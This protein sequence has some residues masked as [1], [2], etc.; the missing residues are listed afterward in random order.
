VL[1][2]LPFL[3]F[4]CLKLWFSNLYITMIADYFLCPSTLNG[5]N[6]SILLSLLS[7]SLIW[8]YLIVDIKLHLSSEFW[9][10]LM[11]LYHWILNICLRF[12]THLLLY[13][14]QLIF[15]S[16]VSKCY[17]TFAFILTFLVISFPSWFVLYTLNRYVI[18]R[19]DSLHHIIL[20]YL[21]A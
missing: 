2:I 15:Y 12:D 18:T 10:I 16:F 17:L 3:L 13:P 1:F 21:S 6:L 14:Y 8:L 11:I 7:I 20:T 19:I 5:F 4:I 9:N